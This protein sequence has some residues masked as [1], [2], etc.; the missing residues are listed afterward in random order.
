MS[1]IFFFIGVSPVDAS[2]CECTRDWQGQTNGKA[3][4]WCR[5]LRLAELDAELGEPAS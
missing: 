3:A 2:R 4:V 5:A 1:A